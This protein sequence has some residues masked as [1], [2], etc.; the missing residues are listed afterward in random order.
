[1]VGGDGADALQD[2]RRAVFGWDAELSDLTRVHGK[3][4]DQSAC[5]NVPQADREVDATGEQVSDVIAVAGVMWIEEAVD[6]SG[7]SLQDLVRWPVFPFAFLDRQQVR[8]D[9]VR[10]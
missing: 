10:R 3:P 7:M 9:G 5:V 8:H 1:M 2:P 6:A 4:V